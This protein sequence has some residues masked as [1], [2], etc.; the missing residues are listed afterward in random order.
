MTNFFITNKTYLCIIFMIALWILLPSRLMMNE[1]FRKKIRMYT[2]YF[3]WCTALALQNEVLSFLF[4]NLPSSFQFVVAFLIAACREFD[5]KVRSKLVTKMM[6]KLDE[7]ASSLIAITISSFYGS[8]VAFRIA[9]ATVTTVFC[10]VSIDFAFHSHITYQLIKEHKKVKDLDSRNGLK[11][12]N[13]K[14]T[15]LILAELVEGLTPMVYA[16]CMAMA[17]YGPN[18]K[19][20]VN[21]GSTFWGKPIKDIN[22]VFRIMGLLYAV[23]TISAIVNSIVLWAVTKINMLQE[24]CR[25]LTKYWLFIVIKLGYIMTTYFVSIDIN[26]GADSSG[27]FE[28]ITSE[29]RINLIYN[30]TYLTTEDITIFENVTLV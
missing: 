5:K 29:G 16:I 20:F 9:G 4:S 18:N 10:V 12:K 24:F 15:K 30:S 22:N 3:A 19:L 11:K 26:F 25:V 27:K 21:I 17:F 1:D 23:D 7:P 28:W 8:F 13:I 6:G 14:A 2:F